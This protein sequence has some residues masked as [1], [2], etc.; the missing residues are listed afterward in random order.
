MHAKWWD[1]E[2]VERNLAARGK[3]TPDDPLTFVGV[4]LSSAEY[5]LERGQLF[6]RGTDRMKPKA[7]NETW[8]RVVL[9][10]P[11]NSGVTLQL[12]HLLL[13]CT[14]LA[15]LRVV[16]Q[17]SLSGFNGVQPTLGLNRNL[18]STRQGRGVFVA[19]MGA[20]L[21]PDGNV[22]QS[23]RV[24]PM[25]AGVRT[26]VEFLCVI[27]PGKAVGFT[28]ELGVQAEAVVNAEWVEADLGG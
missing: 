18:A 1:G 20:E 15:W 26:P 3:G 7:N 12:E 28:A 25:P 17:P 19:D 16:Y 2:G 8:L 11:P 5:A 4:R 22:P 23:G 13:F 6:G 9:L 24:I 14:Q 21:R 10:N 27:P